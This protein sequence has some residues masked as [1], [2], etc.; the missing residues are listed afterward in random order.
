MN[1]YEHILV[2]V[3]FSKKLTQ[4]NFM[5][6]GYPYILQLLKKFIAV[7]KKQIWWQAWI[8]APDIGQCPAKTWRKLLY[9]EHS[10]PACN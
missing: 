4:I 7:L 8:L 6:L 3:I 5:H 1:F 2:F 9:K 10:C